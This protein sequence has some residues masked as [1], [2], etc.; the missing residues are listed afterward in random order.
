[1]TPTTGADYNLFVT[2]DSST[3]A[4]DEGHIDCAPHSGTGVAETCDS[5]TSGFPL[6]ISAGKPTL[7]AVTEGTGKANGGKYSLSVICSKPT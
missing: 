2:W 3:G 4:W 1:M 6:G 5:T 7:I